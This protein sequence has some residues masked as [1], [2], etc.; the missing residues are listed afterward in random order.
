MRSRGDST[1]ID[2]HGRN[3]EQALICVLEALARSE[4]R[5][6][7]VLR[8]IHGKGSYALASE[9]ERLC[10]VDPRVERHERD[11][12]NDG[13]TQIFLNERRLGAR[14]T[15]TRIALGLLDPPERRRR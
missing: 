10:Q 11:P 6:G 14:D 12:S 9:V 5:K 3:S 4:G 2:L 15:Q 1:D 7:A 13:V 8:I